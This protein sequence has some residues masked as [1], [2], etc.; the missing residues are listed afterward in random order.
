MRLLER[1]QVIHLAVRLHRDHTPHEL[2]ALEPGEAT[3][4]RHHDRA[5]H[6]VP[7]LQA[8][9]DLHLHEHLM[10]RSHDLQTEVQQEEHHEATLHLATRPHR[11][12]GLVMRDLHLEH[13]L[14]DQAHQVMLVPHR[15]V[16]EQH[17]HLEAI[18]RQAVHP[19]PE[20]VDTQEDLQL[21]FQ[22]EADSEDLLAD[23]ADV[24]LAD[25]VD[26]EEADEDVAQ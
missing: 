16:T 5:T 21:D 7:A 3:R 23:L 25:S 26:H 15:E 14:L 20:Q 17:L 22:V 9:A 10:D 2:Q 8:T 1:D 4:H 12:A 11:E 6:L 13:I 18:R 24:H 19:A